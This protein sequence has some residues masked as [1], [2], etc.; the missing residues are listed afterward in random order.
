ML[1]RELFKF[2]DEVMTALAA[3]RAVVALESTVIAH[4][5]PRPQNLETALRLEAIVREHGATPAT[6]AVLDRRLCVGLD[7]DQLA[8][9][10]DG[11][12]VH[13]LSRRDLPVALA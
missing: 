1:N 6:I 12:D 13:K 2:S 9:L 8:R 10:A 5:L 11:A 7:D 4:G 3:E